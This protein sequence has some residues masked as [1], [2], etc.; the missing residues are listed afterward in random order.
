MGAWGIPALNTLLLLS[1]GVTV[2]IAHWMLRKNRRGPL[3]FWLLATVALG[4]TFL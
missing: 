2:T 1:S 4:A 3:A